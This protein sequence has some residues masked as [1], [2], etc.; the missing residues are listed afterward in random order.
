MEVARKLVGGPSS[1]ELGI[2]EI[3]LLP[4]PFNLSLI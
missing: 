3:S 1:L 2:K 4:W